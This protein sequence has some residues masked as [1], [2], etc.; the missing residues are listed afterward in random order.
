MYDI[1]IGRLYARPGVLL[2]HHRHWCMDHDH[3]WKCSRKNCPVG[4]VAPCPQAEGKGEA[5][6]H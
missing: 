5:H 1:E 3:E 4:W 6:G 2:D